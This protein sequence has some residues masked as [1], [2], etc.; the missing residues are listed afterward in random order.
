MKKSKKAVKK[1]AKKQRMA[2]AKRAA[3]LRR[4]KAAKK[5][6]STPEVRTPRMDTLS[7]MAASRRKR[8]KDATR[9]FQ[10]ALHPPGVGG[11]R[12]AMDENVSAISAW[13]ANSVYTGAFQEGLGFLGYPYLSELQQRPEY[14]RVTEVIATEMTRR[15]ITIKSKSDDDE[16]KADRIDL[17]QA[18]LEKHKVRDHFRKM[19]ELDGAFGRGHL[20]LDVRTDLLENEKSELLSPIADEN[21][22][23]IRGKVTLG[24]L[25]RIKAV[26]PLWCY[27]ANYNSSDPLSVDWYNPKTWIVMSTEIDRSRLL[28]FVGREVPDLLKPAY[29]FGGLS[30]SQMIKPYVDNWLQTRQ[31]VSDLISAYS[32]MVLKTNMQTSL[33]PSKNQ[34]SLSDRAELFNNYRDNRGLMVLDKDSEDF[35]NVTTPLGGLELLQAQSQEH[36]ASVAGIPIVKLLGIQPAGLNASSEGEIRTFYDWIM[37]Y[38]EKFFGDQLRYV[39]NV[40]MLSEFGEI[41]EDIVFQFNSL[42]MLTEKEQAEVRKIE[43]ETD[44]VLIN[45]CGSLS[46]EESRQRIANDP[47]TPYENIDVDDM[48]EP[49]EDE[50]SLGLT[51]HAPL[52]PDQ[53]EI[54]D[55]EQTEP[56]PGEKPKPFEKKED[57]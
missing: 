37:A 47:T 27:P 11:A 29:S 17:I 28:T 16:A 21:G 25:H 23:L 35:T 46:P 33:A 5:I 6:T 22:N 19:A 48:P 14:R 40:I 56:A 4:R 42:W 38:Q 31:S 51:G 30:L 41:D 32:V 57:A 3:T 15:W 8:R 2:A 26:E 55:G 54:K 24:S 53:P 18:A 49:P 39:I 43:A 7:V 50:E 20:Y 12:L 36:M 52:D 1:V 34:L 45:G 44:D 9:T 13:A 10:P